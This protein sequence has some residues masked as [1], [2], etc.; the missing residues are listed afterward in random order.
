[1]YPSG[2][3]GRARRLEAL[4]VPL[5]AR[6]IDCSED[7]LRAVLEVET[8][9]GGYDRL[10]RPSMLFEPH[11]LWSELGPGQK[12]VAAEAQ[13]LAYRKWGELPYPADSYP[14]LARALKVDVNAALRSA[15]WGL[16][17]ILGRNH[18]AAGYASAG[19]MV[20]A[21]C[22]SETAQL[23]GMVSFIAAEG[24]ADDL[25]RCDWS[26]FARG[27]NGP[28][29]AQHGY[30]KKLAAAFARWQRI[31]D[32]VLDPERP[33][34][35]LGSRGDAVRLAQQ[36]L[37]ALGFA[38]GDIDGRFGPMTHT[39]VCAWQKSLGREAHGIIDP[40]GWDLLLKEV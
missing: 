10:G 28:G 27:Y 13:G 9:G 30:H 14:R 12:R 5:L 3:I 17:Q 40:A 29:Y 18:R 23:E 34:L 38:L 35:G 33:R 25:Q 20:A 39:A 11:R 16:G 37:T 26:G 4:D 31:P 36:R 22:E 8:R 1:M 15:S 32:L 19:E 6:R 21:F 7:A 2:F 24:L